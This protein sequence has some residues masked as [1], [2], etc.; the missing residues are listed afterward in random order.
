MN[1]YLGA[2]QAGQAL[3]NAEDFWRSRSLEERRAFAELCLNISDTLDHIH[4]TLRR[5]RNPDRLLRKLHRYAMRLPEI[6]THLK[7][8]DPV[9][10]SKN[11]VARRPAGEL[12]QLYSH[13]GICRELPILYAKAADEFELLSDDIDLLDYCAGP[14]PASLNNSVHFSRTALRSQPRAGLKPGQGPF[15]PFKSL[16]T[17]R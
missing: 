11:L 9:I 14:A 6:C 1:C 15:A 17:A 12:Y 16:R 4:I 2:I 13:N 10:I 5:Q 8:P 3:R 7:D